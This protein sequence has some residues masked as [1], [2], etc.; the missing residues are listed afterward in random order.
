MTKTKHE[1]LPCVPGALHGGL[2]RTEFYDGMVLGEEDMKREQ[3]Y[4][5]MKRRLTNRALGSGV[6]WGLSVQ[7]D[8]KARA[9]TLCP[10]YGLSCCGDDL[11]VECAST[12]GEREL[13]DICSEDFREILKAGSG[14]CEDPCER[15]DGPVEACLMLEYVEC[16]EDPRQV[17]EDPCATLPGGCRPSAVRETTRLRLVPPP[18]EPGP[19][20]M[21]RFCEKIDK[22]RDMLAEAGHE[23][24]EPEI[25]HAPSV[26]AHAPYAPPAVQMQVQLK[27]AAGN[28][29]EDRREWVPTVAGQST[30]VT[31]QNAAARSIDFTLTPPLGYGF[32]MTRDETGTEKRIETLMELAFTESDLA[33]NGRMDRRF[34]AELAPLAGGSSYEVDYRIEAVGGNTIA[35]SARVEAV[36]GPKRVPDCGTLMKGWV[37]DVSP[38]CA[39]RT[40]LLAAVWGWFR[41]LIGTAPCNDPADEPDRTRAAISAL[42][43]WLAWRVLWKIDLRDPKAAQAERCLRQLFQEWCAEFNYRGPR[44]HGNL[45]GIYLGC[46]KVSRKGKILCF[47]EWAH[48]R[49]VLT[50]PLLTHWTGLFG[51]APMD[52]MATRLASWICCVARTPDVDLGPDEIEAIQAQLMTQDG[53]LRLGG[54]QTFSIGKLLDGSLMGGFQPAPGFPAP[55]APVEEVA[56]FA[57]QVNRHLEARVEAAPILAKAS[58]LDLMREVRATVS[59]SDLKPVGDGTLFDATLGALGRADVATL[60][61][62]LAR[63]PEVLAKRIGPELVEDGAIEDAVSA[64]KAVGLVFTAALKALESVG[65]AVGAVARE[66]DDDEP[67]TRTDLKETATT[68]AIRKALNEHLRGRGLSA[69]AV[70]GMA[71]KVADR[72]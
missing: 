66:R 23:A 50:G 4:W 38:A 3:S 21:E 10:G 65:D 17:F 35:V 40:L 72:H 43:S 44:C 64:E 12:V 62:L 42:V 7:W 59:L 8:E 19:G 61:D 9:F 31:F 28:D 14:P 60:D 6:V 32:L 55:A 11:V 29:I 39:A 47:D 24:P 56:V 52:V 41:G 67:F 48:R 63:D 46:V 22:L 5:Q 25:G 57:T 58:A 30:D 13:I 49:Y 68:S 27:D 37:F 26:Q 2:R 51:V 18:C 53:Q 33:Q 20:P 16:P 36:R 1:F 71:G 70:K 34:T 45:H 54:G 15:P 69:V